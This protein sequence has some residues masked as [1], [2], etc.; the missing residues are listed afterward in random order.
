MRAVPPRA[1]QRLRLSPEAQEREIPLLGRLCGLVDSY[2]AMVTKRP[3]S[4]HMD[5]AQAAQSLLQD[6]KRYDGNLAKM[7]QSFIL[8]GK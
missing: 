7:L 2:C 8:T 1:H 3:Y 4:R 6:D 5:P